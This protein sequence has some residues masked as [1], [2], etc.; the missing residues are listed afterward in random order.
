MT[1]YLPVVLAIL[2]LFVGPLLHSIPHWRLWDP[3]LD[4]FTLAAVAGLC[5][6][7][8]L[9]QALEHGGF[10]A[11]VFAGVGLLL[12]PF[13]HGLRGFGPW[14]LLIG[15]AA[16]AAIEAAALATPG[17][18]GSLGL[19]VV[20]HRL[21]VGLAVFALYQEHSHKNA[22]AWS[23]V[24]FLAVATALGFLSGP[25]I[26]GSFGESGQSALD[27][28]V[29]GMLMHIVWEHGTAGHGHSHVDSAHGPE[30]DHHAPSVAHGPLVALVTTVG[31]TIAVAV[32]LQDPHGR[33]LV[34][35]G[36]TLA[37]RSS[38]VLVGGFALALATG[39]LE[40]LSTL[41]DH[42]L[43]WLWF[44]LL[45]ASYGVALLDPT[46]PGEL[47]DAL[48]GARVIEFIS[49]TGLLF[50]SLATLVRRGPRGMVHTLLRSH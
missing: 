15:L 7:H 4:S 18:H 2:G 31:L 50:L 37:L 35:I 11:I 19:A 21:P 12:P 43:P 34:D 1:E 17:G 42:A 5:T 26:V 44:A 39:G 45:I 29:A 48:P 47:I 10:V 46:V 33:E 30:H 49:A 22:V 9:P 27:A 20:L 14:V 16:H 6:L 8:L 3:L 24:G 13:L 25:Q 41:A 23:A 32:T 38:P 36:S 40:R 28:A